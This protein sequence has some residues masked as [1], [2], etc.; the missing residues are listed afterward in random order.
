MKAP[1][2]LKLEVNR[3]KSGTRPPEEGSFLGF[4]IEGEKIAMSKK[5]IQKYKRK[6]REHW[7]V[8]CGYG[9][10]G[11]EVV[12]EWKS[13]VRG[14]MGYFRLSERT[15]DWEDL[16]PWTR[17]HMRKWFWQRW[18]NWKGRRHGQPQ[19][20]ANGMSGGVGGVTGAIPSPRPDL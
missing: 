15:W 13:Y 8:N 5:S 4:R 18:H 12:E 7:D 16:G 11:S 14:W 19:D 9:K 3:A 6:V 20:A 2:N 10:T 1:E 17:R